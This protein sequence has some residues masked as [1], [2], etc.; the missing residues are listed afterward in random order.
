ML[1][2]TLISGRHVTCQ[3]GGRRPLGS[4]LCLRREGKDAEQIHE[5]NSWRRWCCNGDV[6]GA[7]AMVLNMNMSS[8]RRRWWRRNTVLRGP[9]RL[10][11]NDMTLM[12]VLWRARQWRRHWVGWWLL[13]LIKVVVGAN[14]GGNAAAEDFVAQLWLLQ[15]LV[16]DPRF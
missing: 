14:Y 9:R 8:L 6:N 2:S 15:W 10:W 16:Q 12:A 4:A 7:V 5:A 3:Y 13:M 1:Q 11:N